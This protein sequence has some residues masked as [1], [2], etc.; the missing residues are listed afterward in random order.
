MPKCLLALGGNYIAAEPI[1]ILPE[2]HHYGLLVFLV[3]CP[4]IV[5]WPRIWE[6]CRNKVGPQKTR[7]VFLF[8]TN[9]R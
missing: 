4:N 8:G 2:P 7:G 5:N 9:E 1:K 3:P 6:K